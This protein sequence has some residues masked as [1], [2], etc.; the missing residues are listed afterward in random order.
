MNERK[1]SILNLTN[2]FAL[3]LVGLLLVGGCGPKGDYSVEEKSEFVTTGEAGGSADAATVYY[4]HFDVN[5]KGEYYKTGQP[6]G[7]WDERDDAAHNAE[8]NI[9]AKGVAKITKVSDDVWGKVLSEQLTMNL[10]EADTLR[11]V[12]GRVDKNTGF[13][14]MLQQP[15]QEE[16]QISERGDG[17]GIHNYDIKAKTGWSGVKTFSVVLVVETKIN[18]AGT[19]V[20]EIWILPAL[21]HDVYVEDFEEPAGQP[22]G[23]WD[24]TNDKGNNAQITG[25]GL[26]AAKFV[27]AGADVWGKVLSDRLTM[28]MDVYSTLSVV[29]TQVDA[30]T[31][32]KVMVQETGS[33]APIQLSKREQG[34]G[35]YVY[36]LA[37]KTGWTG[38][39]TFSIMLVVEARSNK[40]GTWIDEILIDEAGF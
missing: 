33:P 36:D 27:K 1:P 9:N 12:I 38:E 37:E 30:N 25:D 16:V 18:G 2:S 28:D 17:A 6:R 19:T 3:V 21:S 29:I 4:E 34:A 7:W 35:V 20:D 23:W 13:K 10:N 15:D 26:G 22:G 5:Q 24:T 11:I 32:Y 8:I 31:G 40:V 14:V 39:K